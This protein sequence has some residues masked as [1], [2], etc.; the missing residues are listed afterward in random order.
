[1]VKTDEELC[2]YKDKAALA[3]HGGSARFKEFNRTVGKEK[4]FESFKVVYTKGAGGF[5][6][7]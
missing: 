6:R 4:L 5:S 1:M 3:A 2:R 7:L